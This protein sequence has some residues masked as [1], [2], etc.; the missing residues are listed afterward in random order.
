MNEKLSLLADL[1]KLAKSDKEFRE[2][3]QRFIYAIAM[4]M[5]VTPDEFTRIFNENIEFTPPK[6]EVDRILQFQRLIL[7]MSVDGFADKKEQQFVKKLGVKMGLNPLAIQ[8]VLSEMHNY[9]NNMLPPERLIEIFK[10]FHN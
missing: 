1:V 6:L 3:E 10:S 9:P 8:T 2:E 5:G 4:Q 7:V